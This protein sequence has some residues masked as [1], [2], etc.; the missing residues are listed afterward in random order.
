M[1]PL[2]HDVERDLHFYRTVVAFRNAVERWQIIRGVVG[3]SDQV[4]WWWGFGYL[5]R[6]WIHRPGESDEPDDFG[7]RDNGPAGSR[8][9]KRPP[10]G[11]GAAG[12]EA[13]VHVEPE[14]SDLDIRR[15]TS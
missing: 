14:E 4:A 13:E 7:P 8:M 11:S 6:P 10:D 1:R 12:A 2:P 3:T 15:V 5:G 9:P